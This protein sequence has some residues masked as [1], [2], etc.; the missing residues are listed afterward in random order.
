[1]AVSVETGN[2]S[3]K[4]ALNADL[5][6]VPYID[7]LTCMVAF[8]LITAVWSQLARLEAHQKG[9]GQA[10]EET[11]PEKMIKLVVVVNG[12]GFNLVA[13]QDQQPIPKRGDQ[14]D[15][16]KLATELKKFKD[17]HPDK[18]DLQV[19]SEDTIKFDT[20]IRTMDTALTAR[21]PDISLIDAGGA[22]I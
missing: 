22:G 21:F 16:E 15:F 14:Y 19:A 9:Q 3:G 10:G 13:D 11:P 17:S 20:L 5:N 4:K 6:L 2:K 18:N 8:L 1:M 7:L 12:E